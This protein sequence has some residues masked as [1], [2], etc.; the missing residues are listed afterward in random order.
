MRGTAADDVPQEPLSVVAYAT[1]LYV[2]VRR[3]AF[4]CQTA[5]KDAAELNANRLGG[6]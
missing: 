3:H 5:R 4:S 2:D 1:L 6:A